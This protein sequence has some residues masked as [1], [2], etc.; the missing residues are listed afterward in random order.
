MGQPLPQTSSGGGFA[1]G[2]GQRVSAGNIHQQQQQHYQVNF[3]FQKNIYV[4]KT[5]ITL[6]KIWSSFQL[7]FL[8]QTI[9]IARKILFQGNTYFDE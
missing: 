9:I 3:I 2:Q 4:S 5:F 6:P 1:Q 7:G 8:S